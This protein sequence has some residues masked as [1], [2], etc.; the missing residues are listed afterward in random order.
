M[1]EDQYVPETCVWELTLR[2]N[3]RCLHCGSVAGRARRNELTLPECLRVADELMALGCTQTTFIG[4]EVALY[5]GWHEIARKLSDGGV[6]VNIA[7]NGFTLPEA[8][9]ERIKYA[10]LANVGVSIDG[11]QVN[12]DRIRNKP[13]SFERALRTIRR[14]R[15]ENILVAVIT[16]LLDFNFDDLEP[17]HDLL[18]ANGVS[19]WQIQLATPM[20]N[21]ASRDGLILKPERIPELTR[22]I[23]EK[24]NEMKMNIYAGDDI[25]YFNEDELYLRGRWGTLCVWQ[26][27]DAGLTVVGI[28]SVGNVKGCESLY[29][30]EF[31]EGNLRDESLAE[32][33]RK[34]GNFAYN[35]NFDVAQLAGK[36]AGCDRA[37]QCRGGCRGS[38]HF[39]TESHFENVY[40]C[41]PGAVSCA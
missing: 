8:E 14:L 19:T 30:D 34:E 3:M 26:G 4:G 11:M 40:C 29:A 15:E 2:C 32:I 1:S 31:I 35:R 17:L 16:C 36:C 12:H 10:K 7:T 9:I 5:K 37:V 41:Y 13:K 21:L 20:G 28:D 39:T 18:V 23:R 6:T 38:A 24:R 25:G 33:W 22:F 27:C